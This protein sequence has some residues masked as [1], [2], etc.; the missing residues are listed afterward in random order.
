MG[1]QPNEAAVVWFAREV[2]PILRVA[3]PSVRLRIVGAQ[4]SSRVKSLGKTPGIEVIGAVTD[5][6]AYLQRASLAVCP[7][8]SGSGIQNKVL[9]AMATGTPVVATAIANRGIQAVDGRDLILAESPEDFAIAI[10]CLMHDPNMRALLAQ[11]GR[12]LVERR[13]DWEGHAERLL[14]LYGG[15]GAKVQPWSP[16]GEIQ[17]VLPLVPRV[18]GGPDARR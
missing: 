5:V 8:Q 13:F 3:E 1:Y 7:M 14:S 17:A 15:S 10:S 11:N 6:A 18:Q 2:W 16:R 12:A 9:E 4:P